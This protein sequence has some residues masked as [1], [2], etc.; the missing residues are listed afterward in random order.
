VR[1]DGGGR[2]T[3]SAVSCDNTARPTEVDQLGR[4]GRTGVLQAVKFT[5]ARQRRRRTVLTCRVMLGVVVLRL[6]VIVRHRQRRVRLQI[7]PLTPL[8]VALPHAS[9][10]RFYT[11]KT[12]RKNI[13]TVIKGPERCR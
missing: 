10:E 3:T 4:V 9:N 7:L 8:R 1:V 12:D 6:V 11:S 2:S 5:V 13:I